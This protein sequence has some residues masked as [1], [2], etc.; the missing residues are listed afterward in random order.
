MITLLTTR[1]YREMITNRAIH[2]NIIAST[3]TPRAKPAQ[4]FR[5]QLLVK[6][7]SWLNEAAAAVKRISTAAVLLT[8]F[9][10]L[11]PATAQ[12][13]ELDP[14]LRGVWHQEPPR[15][16]SDV[17]SVAVQDGFAFV[18]LQESGLAIID[19]REPANPI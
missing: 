12:T 5:I 15:E 8:R 19:I 14:V 3:R 2:M 9:V 4:R 11:V 13:A 7:C 18:A 1:V 16:H 17:R 10:L 6:L